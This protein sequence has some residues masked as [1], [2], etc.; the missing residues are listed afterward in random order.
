MLKQKLPQKD[1]D[2]QAKAG[3]Y[4]T[5]AAIKATAT[6]VPCD[7]LIWKKQGTGWTLFSAPAGI[8]T[9]HKCWMTLVDKHIQLLVG[10]APVPTD[11][12]AEWKK[13][14]RPYLHHFSGGG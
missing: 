13:N 14:A 10:T 5:S 1:A 4:A 9:K 2:D 11:I 6:A 12:E 8:K 3:T 7:Y